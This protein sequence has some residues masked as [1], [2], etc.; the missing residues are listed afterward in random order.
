MRQNNKFPLSQGL[1]PSYWDRFVF[2]G[3]WPPHQIRRWWWIGTPP[4]P[5]YMKFFHMEGYFIS[6]INPC[7]CIC[8]VHYI[9]PSILFF[10]FVVPKMY[11]L[12]LIFF[13]LGEQELFLCMVVHV[14][15]IFPA[16][17]LN[18]H[19]YVGKYQIISPLMFWGGVY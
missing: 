3:I 2:M 4:L 13:C 15:G 8:C 17:P 19:M 6:N 16:V 1:H 14:N 11:V 9:L 18:H 7:Y 12:F 5:H 10:G